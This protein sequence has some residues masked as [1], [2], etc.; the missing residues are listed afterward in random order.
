LRQS[1]L[2]GLGI[3]MIDR[4]CRAL[5]TVTVPARTPSIFGVFQAELGVA[6]LTDKLDGNF[7]LIGFVPFALLLKV[8]VTLEAPGVRAW[9]LWTRTLRT[10]K[11]PGLR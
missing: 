8:L 7:A 1:L 4:P 5:Q 3:E 9:L 6:A 11:L 10:P 2:L